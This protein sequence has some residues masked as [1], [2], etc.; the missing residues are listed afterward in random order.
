LEPYGIKNLRAVDATRK[1]IQ[2][3]KKVTIT[4]EEFVRKNE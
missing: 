4:V 2:Y 3:R 1:I